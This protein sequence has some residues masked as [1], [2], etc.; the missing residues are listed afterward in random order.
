MITA[1]S[2]RFFQRRQ[3]FPVRLAQILF[4]NGPA[5]QDAHCLDIHELFR[6][7]RPSVQGFVER[8]RV[9]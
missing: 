9:F 5:C 1:R 4:P 8:G 2:R 7:K 3:A 6:V